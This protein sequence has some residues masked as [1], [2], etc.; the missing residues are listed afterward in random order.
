MTAE[1]LTVEWEWQPAGMLRLEAM[2]LRFPSVRDEPGIYRFRL[3]RNRV[4]LR[5]DEVADRDEPAHRV[6]LDHRQVADAAPG[7]QFERVLD[8]G[9]G[10]R[11]DRRRGHHLAHGFREALSRQISATSAISSSRKPNTAR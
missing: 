9:I 4:E 11:G 10:A 1:A 5:L 2:R 6:A 7:H 8:P 3:V